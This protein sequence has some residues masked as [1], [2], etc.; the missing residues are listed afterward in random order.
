[1]VTVRSGVFLEAVFWIF[2][3]GAALYSMVATVCDA[4]ERVWEGVTAPSPNQKRCERSE[5]VFGG[6]GR[7]KRFF[8]ATQ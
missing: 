5:L 7:L 1:M 3:E 8:A 6:S 2:G 4:L